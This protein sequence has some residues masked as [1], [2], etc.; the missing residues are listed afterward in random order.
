MVMTDD[1][2]ITDSI[3]N[4]DAVFLV[5]AYNMDKTHREGYPAINDF[6]LD[7]EKAGY[8]V[9][10]LSA[11]LPSVVE[12]MRH[13]LQTPFPF[14]AMDETTLKTIIRSNPGLVLVKK[15][16]IVKKWHFNDVP[17]FAE[18]KDQL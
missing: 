10:G 15:G 18:V 4:L 17:S 1:G 16:N 9:L 14:V 8:P 6:A 13:E 3:L 2:D 12:E 5:I 11:A 7:A